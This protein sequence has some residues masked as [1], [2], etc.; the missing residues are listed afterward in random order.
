MIIVCANFSWSRDQAIEFL[1]NYTANPIDDIRIEIDRYITWPGQAC[2]YKIGEIKIWQLRQ[3]AQKELG[4][5]GQNKTKQK[6]V[7][8]KMFSWNKKNTP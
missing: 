6:F 3:K 4:K 5:D 8:S 7:N 2:A 1:K